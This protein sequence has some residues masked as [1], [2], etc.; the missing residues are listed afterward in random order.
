MFND[1]LKMFYHKFSLGRKELIVFVTDGKE[2]LVRY[3][4]IMSDFE[5]RSSF[6]Q[7]KGE[8]LKILQIQ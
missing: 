3:S 7:A 2:N 8:F 6:Y 4:I 5:G 1:A